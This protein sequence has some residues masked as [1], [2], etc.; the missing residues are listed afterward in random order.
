MND[1]QGVK[2]PPLVPDLW[3]AG[4]GLVLDADDPHLITIGHWI[5]D[6]RQDCGRTYTVAQLCDRV[7]EQQAELNYL[8]SGLALL[9][10]R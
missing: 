2:L 4:C 5:D 9:V 3:C 6:D 8:V 1:T 7:Q 10:D